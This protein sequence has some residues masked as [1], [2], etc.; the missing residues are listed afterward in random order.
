MVG[1]RISLVTDST[2]DIPA[3]LLKEY[4]IIVVPLF[5]IWGEEALRDRVDIQPEAFYRRLR[6]D[7]NFPTT[8]QPAPGDFLRAYQAAKRDGSEEVVVITVSSPLSGTMESAI[9]AA[10]MA[11]ISI[12]IVDSRGVTMGLGWQVLAAARAREAGGDAAAMVEA[13]DKARE[14][15]VLLVCLDTLEYLHRGG[16]IGGAAKFV[17][18]M[19]K[20][21][22]LI[23][24]NHTT[25]LIEAGKRVRTRKKALQAL[26]QEF[27]DSLDI[28]KRTRIAVLH[29]DARGDAEK[30]A[31]RVRR[32]F[33][34]A[35]IIMNTT[36]P[37]IGIHTGPGAIALCGYSED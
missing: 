25:G 28:S 9:Q 18:T 6:T 5:V 7:L 14:S 27:S 21:K 10:S 30:L 12:T 3:D 31:D 2:C 34:P 15:M 23:L 1:K 11:D 16:R 20:L 19:L 36:G 24:V 17:G 35:E 13:A 22:P 4:G 8:T 29:G 26:V 33:S 32:E 37:V